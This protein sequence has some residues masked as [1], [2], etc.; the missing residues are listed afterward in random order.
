MHVAT[1]PHCG[2]ENN[3]RVGT[4]QTLQDDI[5]K[6]LYK[7]CFQKFISKF[8][9]VYPDKLLA[10]IQSLRM[11]SADRIER[12]IGVHMKSGKA[13]NQGTGAV[14]R[15]NQTMIQDNTS[16]K[17]NPKHGSLIEVT[18]LDH[19]CFHRLNPQSLY[20]CKRR[21]VGWLIKENP[22][23]L[24]L[25]YDRPVF[26]EPDKTSNFK[27]IEQPCG[28]VLLKICILKIKKLGKS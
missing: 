2:S 17:G 11:F 6:R 26:T 22:H 14:K 4:R 18:Y 19:L 12:Q 28:L 25:V 13:K 24:F 27:E 10:T 9:F 21:A 1:C 8:L 3:C 23:C 16:K 15:A 20:L 5:Q 7:E